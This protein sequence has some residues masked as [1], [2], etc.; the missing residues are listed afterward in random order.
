MIDSFRGKYRFLSNFYPA[1]MKYRG[2]LFPS[3]E[4]A[5]QSAKATNPTLISLFTDP[6]MTP[7]QAKKLGADIEKRADWHDVSLDIME[8]V[9]TEKFVSNPKLAQKLLDTGDEELV[10][11]NN[12]DDTFWGCVD[13]KGENHLG[14]I[15]MKVREKLRVA[16]G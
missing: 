11:G 5:Y 10:E 7:G 9:V 2:W 14:K 4:H 6:T 1:I 13:G 8:T 12:W 3:S 16:K 15:L